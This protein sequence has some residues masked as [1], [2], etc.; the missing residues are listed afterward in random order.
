M[1]AQ[2][3]PMEITICDL[4]FT[5]YD[6]SANG[7]QIGNLLTNTATAVSNGLF[8]VTLDFGN[9]FPGAGRWLEIGVRTNGSASAYTTLSPRQ[10]LTSRTLRH[11][12]QQSHRHPARR[13][14]ERPG[15]FGEFVR[16]LWQCSDAEQR[17]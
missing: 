4:R 2:I 14:I 3:R 7:N 8:T 9:Q 1:T 5:I 16:R 6:S 13:A 15:G 17:G 11:H 12:R 10:P